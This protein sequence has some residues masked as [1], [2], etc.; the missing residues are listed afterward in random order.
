MLS[1]CIATYNGSQFINAQLQSILPQL[2]EDDEIIISDD[3]S[4]D[5][6]L[7]NIKTLSDPRIK[8]ITN[9][10]RQGV[11]KNFERALAAA[12]GDYIFLSDQ[13]DVWLPGK[14]SASLQILQHHLLVV[15][16]CTVTDWQLQP[17]HASFFNLRNSG[18][19]ILK[20]I[21]K[22]S[23]LGCCM[24]FRRELLSFALPIPKQVPMH[25]MWLGIIAESYGQVFFLPIPYILY[26]RHQHTASPTAGQSRFS[27]YAKLRYRLILV[28]FLA[29]RWF[30]NYNFKFF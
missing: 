6:T 26:R 18:S 28:Y 19:G 21:I 22:N 1:V 24:A 16:D 12:K 27:L 4:A 2:S 5:E 29:T 14:V 30:A 20:N 25:D 8:I 7:I 9:S 23:Y 11:I 15:T 10:S 13:D 3:N 17:L